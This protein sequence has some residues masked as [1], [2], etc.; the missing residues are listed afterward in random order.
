MKHFT[1]IRRKKLAAFL[2]LA[3]LS[4][5]CK[6]SHTQGP[7]LPP[8]THQGLNT[9][10]CKVN[11]QV[12]VPY[13][14]CFYNQSAIKTYI[15]PLQRGSILP[16]SFQL[17]LSTFYGQGNGD[18]FFAILPGQ[19]V[20]YTGI[21]GT[22]NYF[23]SLDI[24]YDGPTSGYSSISAFTIQ[25]RNSFQI[26][27]LDTVNGIIAGTFAFTLYGTPTDSLVVTDGRFDFKF[28]ILDSCNN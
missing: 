25:G 26:T 4:A 5:S 3:I 21:H 28:G 20:P 18:S 24:E 12:W 9:F 13:Y 2:L 16:I 17:N 11:G 10:G 8:I 23:D 27:T 15:V 19:G 1:H 22:Y 7:T 6:K 14:P